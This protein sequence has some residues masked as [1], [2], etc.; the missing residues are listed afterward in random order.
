MHITKSVEAPFF[1]SDFVVTKPDP[2]Q[3]KET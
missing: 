2:G 1:Q 3:Q